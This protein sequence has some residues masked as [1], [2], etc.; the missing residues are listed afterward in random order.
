MKTV[1]LIFKKYATHH[2]GLGIG[3]CYKAILL[4]CEVQNCCSL[5]AH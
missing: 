4:F 2:L 1:F 5:L 3:E